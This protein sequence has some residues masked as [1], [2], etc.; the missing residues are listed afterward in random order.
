M[1]GGEVKENRGITIAKN[2]SPDCCN[3]EL[4]W[5]WNGNNS[6]YH[7]TTESKFID[8]WLA[9]RL[10]TGTRKIADDVHFVAYVSINFGCLWK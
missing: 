1:A 2:P 10:L 4:Y 7:Y 5:N 8:Q 6:T 3:I 9:G